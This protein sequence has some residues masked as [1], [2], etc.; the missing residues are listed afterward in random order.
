MCLCY[1]KHCFVVRGCICIECICL[2]L[3]L[4]LRS[5]GC[6]Q[7]GAARRVGVVVGVCVCGGG[8]LLPGICSSNIKR[9]PIYEEEVNHNSRGGVAAYSH[10]QCVN[11]DNRAPTPECSF[12]L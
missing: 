11:P 7:G 3:S 1:W 5:S 4:L 10:I 9:F 12:I 2:L 6:N 8:S